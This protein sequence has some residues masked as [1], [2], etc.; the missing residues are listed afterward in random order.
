MKIKMLKEFFYKKK[1]TTNG[2][3]K[4]YICGIQVFVKKL[5]TIEKLR[6]EFNE[7]FELKTNIHNC[8]EEEN[9]K[10][11]SPRLIQDINI[12]K[13]SYVADNAIITMTDIGRF[14]SIGPNLVCGYGIHPTNGISTSPCFYSTLKQNGMTYSSNDKIV[15]RK[16]IT[17]GNDVFI[18][19]NVSILDGVKIGDG[20]II[21]AGAVVTKDVP[22]YAIV[23]GVPAK[24]IK[25]RFNQD[26]IDKL[27]KI[28]WWNWADDKLKNI[29]KMFFNVEEFVNKFYN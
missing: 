29:E 21:A 22:P 1:Q 2:T 6:H 8:T 23:G 10:I 4:Y 11:I 13:G 25:Y 26:I 19:M 7:K 9:V 16:K 27:M 20:A 15:E 12:G 28:Q 24:I 17:I 18:G 3:K 14:C 5:S